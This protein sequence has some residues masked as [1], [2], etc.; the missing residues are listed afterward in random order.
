MAMM[1][2]IPVLDPDSPRQARDM[3]D[4]AYALSEEFEI[5]VMLRPTTRVCHARQD[6]VL[7]PPAALE[8]HADFEKDPTRWAA[9][10]KFRQKLHGE[11]EAKLAA[12]AQHAPTAPQRL[13]PESASKRAVVV[14]G[15]AT[16][17]TVEIVK[18]LGLWS[19]F[20]VY[21]VRQPYP[22]HRSFVDHLRRTY[23]EVDYVRARMNSAMLRT[24][25]SSSAPGPSLRI[26]RMLSSISACAMV[27][28]NCAH[29]IKSGCKSR[30][31][32]SATS[33]MSKQRA[34][35]ILL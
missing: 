16:A 35:V 20:T 11:L 13:N 10:P 27:M 18:D 7:R 4:L 5:P 6:V 33:S 31:E 30:Q 19:D 24:E 29:L 28:S 26:I 14:S 8:R 34:E 2:K 3:I 32:R 23:A 1:A 17:H 25:K 9:T 15:V 22:L 21:Q 12:I